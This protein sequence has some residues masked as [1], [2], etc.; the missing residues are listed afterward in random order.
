MLN[1]LFFPKTTL[2]HDNTF[3]VRTGVGSDRDR[4]L[5]IEILS[6]IFTA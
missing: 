4:D 2:V 3:D 6:T 1:I 5:K